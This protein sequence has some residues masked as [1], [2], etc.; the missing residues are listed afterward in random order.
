MSRIHVI[1]GGGMPRVA[2]AHVLPTLHRH[3]VGA[4]VTSRS[5]AT[6]SKGPYASVGTLPRCR[7]GF[8]GALARGREV[9]YDYAYAAGP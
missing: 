4:M 7:A 1:V 6:H 5:L 9:K 2:R 8:S 3:S